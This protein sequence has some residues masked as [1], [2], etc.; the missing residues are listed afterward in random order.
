MHC[1]FGRILFVDPP[2][3][4]SA[5]SQ[6]HTGALCRKGAKWDDRKPVFEKQIEDLKS[7]NTW[8]LVYPPPNTDILPGKWGLGSTPKVNGTEA[9]HAGFSGKIENAESWS[10][11][12]V[13]A[14]VA[15][16]ASVRLFFTL[17][18]IN[19]YECYQY[20]VVTAFLNAT[21]KGNPIYIEQP[22]SF[23]DGT[24]RVSGRLNRALYG[25]RK[26]P[27]WWF[28]TICEALK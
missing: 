19:D 26:V 21:C 23:T 16:S 6:S 8:D 2:I 5:E 4:T 28:E 3:G 13:Y 15:N 7:R 9:T 20:D 1:A 10:A 25:L 17:V 14:A 18:T 27:L 12:D 24:T 22:H 11:Q